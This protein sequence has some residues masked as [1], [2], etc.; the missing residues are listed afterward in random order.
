[1]KYIY[2]DCILIFEIHGKLAPR[3]KVH[4]PNCGDNVVTENYITPL[5]KTAIGEQKHYRNYYW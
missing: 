2:N 1:M 4:C 3:K 5:N